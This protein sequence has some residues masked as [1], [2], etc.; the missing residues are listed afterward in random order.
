MIHMSINFIFGLSIAYVEKIAFAHE[1]KR[2]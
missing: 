1:G 2:I